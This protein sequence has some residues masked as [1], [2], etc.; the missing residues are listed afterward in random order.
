MEN[1]GYE[2]DRSKKGDVEILSSN[3]N[4][5]EK[6]EDQISNPG[7]SASEETPVVNIFEVKDAGEKVEPNL[8]KGDGT[9]RMKRQIG[10]IGGISMIVGTMIGSGIFIS[11]GNLL[12]KTDS[13]ATSL[14]VWAA[15]GLLTTFTA[16]TYCELGTVV[17]RSGGEHAYYM[18]AYTPLHRFFGELPAFLFAFMTVTLLK[19][20]SLAI[21]SLTFGQYAMEPILKA[22]G[23]DEA[24]KSTAEYDYARK[25]LAAVVALFI[26]FVNVYSAKIATRIQIFFTGAKITA[27]LILIG[28]GVYNVAN[29]EYGGIPMEYDTSS[30]NYGQ[31]AMAFYS[32]LWSY[33]GW[34]NLNFVTEELI[35]P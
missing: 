29:G 25:C 24:F 11:P 6:Y 4:S 13:V 26:G 16:L 27:M 28:V 30:A 9:V 17:P 8:T 3:S 1:Q 34:N 10:L 5:G 33:E 20:S 12:A 19:P 23:A 2:D 7:S 14:V 15:C 35:E 21:I 22:M 32:G 18:A 31:I